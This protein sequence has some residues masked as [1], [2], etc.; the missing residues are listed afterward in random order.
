MVVKPIRRAGVMVLTRD[1][2]A[3][4]YTDICRHIEVSCSWIWLV[5][6]NW[7]GPVDRDTAQDKTEKQ[8]HVQ[9]VTPAHQN[10]VSLNHEH[11]WLYQQRA[12][13]V[14]FVMKCGRRVHPLNP[15][16]HCLVGGSRRN[17]LEG[18]VR[19]DCSV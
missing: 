6:K 1:V 19:L 14:R 9:P 8:R 15:E 12:P 2:R 3:D 7:R 5:L 10:M 13:G 18:L 16:L 4:P 17:K 11:A